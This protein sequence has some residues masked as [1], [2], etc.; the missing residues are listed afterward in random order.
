[1]KKL[2]VIIAIAGLAVL[3]ISLLPLKGPDRDPEMSAIQSLHTVANAMY[4][5]REV[6][7]RFPNSFAEVADDLPGDL[8]KGEKDGYRFSITGTQN[9]YSI[10]A[11][12][13]HYGGRSKRSFCLDQSGT[14]RV[15]K[16]PEPANPSSPVLS[17]SESLRPEQSGR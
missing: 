15:S 5:R 2:F 4:G 7:N 1:M 14:L 16:G 3:A 11:L 17:P 10:T 12:P 13:I 9:S 8:R 6:S